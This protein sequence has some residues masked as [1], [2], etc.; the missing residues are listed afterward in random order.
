MKKIIALLLAA[1]AFGL[2]AANVTIPAFADTVTIDEDGSEVTETPEPTVG[3]EQ[4][5][6]VNT[7]EAPQID[8]GEN[9]EDS[10]D[11]MGNNN[12]GGGA[13]GGDGFYGVSFPDCKGHW[14]EKII[15][16]SAKNKYLDGYDDGNFYPD[17]PVTASQYAKIYSA[18]KG[19]FY[20]ITSGYWATPYIISMLN[21]GVYENGD[22]SD[23]DEPMTREQV[24]KA[25]IK[26]LKSE[27]FPSDFS[28]YEKMISDIDDA[29]AEYKDYMTK[30]YISGIIGGYEDGTVRPKGTVTRA[31]VLS[32]INR[33]LNSDARELPKAV[34]EAAADLP[35]VNTYYTAA[36]QVRN[37]GNAASMNYRLLGKN[38]QYMTED[39]P[40]SGLKMAEEMQ[41]ANGFAFLMRYDLTDI[42]KREDK[43]TS[44]SLTFK[45]QSGGDLDLGLF[46]Y[47]RGISNVD[48]NNQDYVQVNNGA[49]VAGAN[50][51]GYNSV[52]D[53]I[54][55]IIP[56][57]NKKDAA[58][59]NESKT[60]PFAEAK[61]TDDKYTFELS[62]DELKAHMDDK[63]IVEFFATT[64]NYDAYG[65]ED[66]K[67]KCYVAGIN[68]P[69]LRTTYE[70]DIPY[71]KEITVYG[72]SAKVE[73]GM[74]NIIGEG[75]SG[76]VENFQKNQKMIFNFNADVSGTYN[77]KIYYSAN[78][79]SGGG[80]AAFDLNG[81]MFEHT[82]AQTGAWALYTYEDL[83]NVE[84]KAGNNI[85]EITD[86]DIPNTYLIN[87]KHMIFTKI[88]E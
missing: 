66:N 14:A 6:S 48:W 23:Y 53:N 68:A 78:V 67:P 16:E 3:P 2:S 19:N 81:E 55:N 13:A 41:G 8:N 10:D 83:G 82:F 64:V 61:L 60:K 39:D 35:E 70:T 34:Q 27:Y 37:N 44:I 50:K 51:E 24:A 58:V 65:I 74:L 36:V 33:A 43:L 80:T 1:S 4:S 7:T 32:I 84:L 63:N 21:T 76:Y 29:D 73:G 79:N 87:V 56:T 47:D 75:E 57:W 20:H 25:V 38:A 59:P 45:H 15:T 77:M 46:W 69:Q 12:Q 40:V 54:A 22:Y 52:I 26:S 9:P 72:T 62:L 28:M 30:A 11:E 17:N 31:E 49:A 42:L 5:D 88:D 18:W 85:L 86:K 71:N